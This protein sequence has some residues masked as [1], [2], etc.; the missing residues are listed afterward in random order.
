LLEGLE[1]RTVPSI[2]FSGASN[3]GIA[4]LT[5]TPG[6]DAFAIGLKAGD[7]TT[8]EFS[9]DNG[10]T[11]TDAALTGITA[12]QVN[13]MRGSDRLR[14]N[15]ANGF[16]A[17]G[18][19]LP[20]TFDGGRG[21]NALIIVGNSGVANISE[22]FAP[23]GPFGG[24][25]AMTDGTSSATI[26][27]QHV[28]HIF[29]VAAAQSLTVNATD[30]N[31]FIHIGYGL[32]PDEGITTNTIRALDFSRVD[33]NGGQEDD[34][35]MVG[36]PTDMSGSGTDGNH[37]ADNP[38][39]VQISRAIIPYTFASKTNVTVNGLGGD[40]LF[41]L[42]VHHAATGL[43]SLT[44]DGGSGMN[45]VAER[46]FPQNTT[47]TLQNIQH[48]V[49]DAVGIFIHQLYMS[50]LGRPAEDSAVSSW[51]QVLV[52]QGQAAVVGAIED[53]TEGRTNV[54]RQLYVHY[55]GRLPGDAEVAA[56]VI[57]LQNGMTEGQLVQAFLGSSEFFSRAQLLANT[58][59]ADQNFAQALFQVAL[60]RT[61]TGIEVTGFGFATAA[62]GTGAVAGIII[63]SPEFRSNAVT[64]L[65]T[66]ILHR[67]PS[68]GELV[69]WVN[70]GLSLSDIRVTFL[71]SA[72]AF[73]NG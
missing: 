36:D 48:T 67:M 59:S 26:T 13:G 23:N 1:D 56:W 46:H 14:I 34:S 25:L 71:S 45:V 20:I 3:S 27:L 6:S 42:N 44:L 8:I 18:G 30:Q 5:G 4:T 31:N 28:D 62:L 70:S 16:V 35:S 68:F 72:E 7:A 10:H 66:S 63:A 49:S 38:T 33:D 11:F 32:V 64:T 2:T 69:A 21:F 41:V 60:N 40:D 54:V 53:S 39:E 17:T 65:Y 19:G 43:S 50:R 61:P 73:A 12:I 57:A 15:E 51:S 52:T 29:D 47:L 9:D 22:T 58:G 37:G 55:L 24:A